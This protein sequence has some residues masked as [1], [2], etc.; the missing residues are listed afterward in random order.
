MSNMNLC[1]ELCK[2]SQPDIL[3]VKNLNVSHYM[4]TFQ[5]NCFIPAILLSTIDFYHFMLHS[6][7]LA[8]PGG[9]K[10]GTKQNLLAS[11]SRRLFNWSE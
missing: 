3:H 5:P 6:L 7:T 4:Q 11:F 1:I 8:L 2:A 10:V 9:H